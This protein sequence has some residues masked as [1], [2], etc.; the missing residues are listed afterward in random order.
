MES[1]NPYTAPS[2]AATFAP[3]IENI[4][5]LDVTDA[6]KEKFAIIQKAG[7]PRLPRFKDLTMGEK[8]KIFSL[9]GFFFG[10][11]YYLYLGMWKKA[12]LYTGIAAALMITLELA[13]LGKIGGGISMA[14][15]A[16]YGTMTSRDYYNKV[17]LGDKTLW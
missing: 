15:G 11:F 2:S 17:V 3:G 16:L 13:G 12:L 10:L 14:V 7:G 4:A 6:W 1:T 5:D 9:L 8:W